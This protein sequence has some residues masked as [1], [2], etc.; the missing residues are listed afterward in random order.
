[1]LKKEEILA[2][3]REENKGV[4]EYELTVL[5]S[6]GKTAAQVGMTMCCVIAILQ[7]ILKNAISYESWMIYFSILGTLFIVKYVRMKR[8][9]ELLLAV[10]YC[11]LFAFFAVLF[12]MRLA[13]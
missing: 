3:S 13:G 10:L 1:M 7:V 4:D 5:A 2:K 9:H 12:V 11:G 6:A 8:K